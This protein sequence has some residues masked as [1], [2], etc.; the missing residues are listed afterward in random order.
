VESPQ[1][2]RFFGAPLT[3]PGQ[4]LSTMK[5]PVQEV[6]EAMRSKQPPPSHQISYAEDAVQPLTQCHSD[7]QCELL[8]PVSCDHHC[9]AIMCPP[10]AIEGV[11][12]GGCLQ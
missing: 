4:L 10:H 5:T 6:V 7:C 2:N 11:G 1:L 9:H 3:Q 12:A 8:A